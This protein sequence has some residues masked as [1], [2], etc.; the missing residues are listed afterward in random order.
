[1]SPEQARG[2]ELDTRTDLFYLGGVIYQ[3][4][5]GRLPFA[6]AT[7]AVIFHAIL[8]LDPVA[9]SQLNSSLPPK[10]QEIIQQALEKNPHPRHQSAAPLRPAPKPLN[11]QP[12]SRP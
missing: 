11:P 4:A 10:L 8:E 7:S 2:E 6:G 5:T 3:M 12:P 9:V 1:M